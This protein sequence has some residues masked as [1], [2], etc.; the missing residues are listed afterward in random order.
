MTALWMK[1]RLDRKKSM[2]VQDI[3]TQKKRTSLPL[4]SQDLDSFLKIPESES[5]SEEPSLQATKDEC[6]ENTNIY[7]S[8]NT[9]SNTGS[10][11]RIDPD[12]QDET[13]CQSNNPCSAN[14]ITEGPSNNL[15]P[16]NERIE[17]PLVKKVADQVVENNN[18]NTT[19]EGMNTDNGKKETCTEETSE[20]VAVKAKQSSD[21]D[22]LPTDSAVIESVEDTSNKDSENSEKEDTLDK[23]FTVEENSMDDD[24]GNV[25]ENEPEMDMECENV[26]DLND[27]SDAEG[28]F[29]KI[30][31]VV[32]NADMV[33]AGFT[34]TKDER[35]NEI[36]LESVD[37]GDSNAEAKESNADTNSM[38]YRTNPRESGDREKTEAVKM[39]NFPVV[40]STCIMATPQFVPIGTDGRLQPIMMCSNVF[41]RYVTQ[42]EG[43]CHTFSRTQ[44][45]TS[46]Y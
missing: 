39:N 42:P 45:L 43:F 9:S 32:G 46:F 13:M 31:N 5:K 18:C 19:L 3:I 27:I 11:P 8:F 33:D 6:K 15:E 28:S 17:H 44:V 26:V 20:S 38:I 35:L 4:Y 21:D 37:N 40:D 34:I 25:D 1:I 7:T 36:S 24:S 16:K 41:N 22:L 10:K 12:L 2:E 30:T 14:V 29:L 23:D